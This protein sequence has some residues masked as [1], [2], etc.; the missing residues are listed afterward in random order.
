MS[1]KNFFKEFLF[2]SDIFLPSLPSIHPLF[3]ICSFKT[4]T[5]YYE[6]DNTHGV[7]LK[8]KIVMVPYCLELN[9]TYFI[10]QALV[11]FL[12]NSTLLPTFP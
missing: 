10:V 1:L 5:V 6:P 2:L 8:N 9:I 12:F 3:V 11:L 7:G 4:G